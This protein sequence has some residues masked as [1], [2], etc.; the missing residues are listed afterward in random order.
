MEPETTG[1]PLTKART[2]LGFV[3]FPL[4]GVLVLLLA[5]QSLNE[6]YGDAAQK[7]W[8]WAL[9]NFLPTLALMTAVFSEDALRPA[10]SDARY[11]RR[12]F[13]ALAMAL[14]L[15]YLALL[16][17][18]VLAP[19]FAGGAPTLE[20]RLAAM[21]MSNLWLGPIQGLVIATVSALFFV[22]QKGPEKDKPA[23]A[24]AAAR[25]S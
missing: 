11:V 16:F 18:A 5:V 25:P 20:R 6:V 2:R 4:A 10:P 8:G 22:R 17:L 3:W 23:S 13:C 15:F 9:P 19:L 7:V 21:E 24:Q 1:L 14:S 12:G